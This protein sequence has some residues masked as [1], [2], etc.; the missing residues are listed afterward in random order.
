ME[1]EFARRHI[2]TEY[3]N[4]QSRITFPREQGPPHAR[5]RGNEKRTRGVQEPAQVGVAGWSCHTQGLKPDPIR[6][7]GGTAEAMP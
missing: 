1:L 6:R 4:Q 5:L 2:G 7:I 3:V